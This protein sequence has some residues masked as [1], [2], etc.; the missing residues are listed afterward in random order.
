MFKKNSI[1]SIIS[2]L[3]VIMPFIITVELCFFYYISMDSSANKCSG[4]CCSSSKKAGK[5]T[6]TN[7]CTCK[8]SSASD[9]DTC[10]K[11]KCSCVLSFNLKINLLNQINSFVNPCH[12]SLGLSE[13]SY[14]HMYLSQGFSN[15]W[16]PPKIVG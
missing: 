9:D 5:P 3:W 11:D 10:A 1:R 7:T 2:K 4:S 14:T 15:P 16:L 13:L 8:H 12:Q 6:M